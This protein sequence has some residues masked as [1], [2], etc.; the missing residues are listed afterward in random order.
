MAVPQYTL[1]SLKTMHS[2]ILQDFESSH[3]LNMA[4]PHVAMKAKAPSCGGRGKFANL[5]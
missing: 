5:M 4:I 2:L 1:Q 3:G